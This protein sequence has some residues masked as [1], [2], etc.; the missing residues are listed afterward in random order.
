M[1]LET[2]GGLD[3][4]FLSLEAP[5]APLQVAAVLLLDPPEGRRSLFSPSTR[6]AQIRR[7]IGERISLVPALR[8]R[9]VPIPLGLHHPV[10]ADDPEFA[11]D[12]HLSRAVLPAPG[13]MAELSDLVAAVM[14]RPLDPDRPLWEVVVVEGMADGRTAMVMKLHHA[15]LDGVSGASLLANFLDLGPRSR[16]VPFP[17]TFDPSPLPGRRDLLAHAAR[18]IVH[19]PGVAVDALSQALDVLVDVSQQNRRLAEEGVTPPPAP[20]SAPRTRLNGT[21][22]S[23]R[24]FASVDLDLGAALAVREAYGATVTDVVLA[25]VAGGLR[26]YLGLEGTDTGDLVAMVPVSV[27]PEAEQDDLG[28]RVSAMLVSLATT[29]GGAVERLAKIAAGSSV[30]KSQHELTGGRLLAD[31]AQIAAPVVATRASRWATGLGLFDRLAPLSNV[32]ISSVRGPDMAIWCAGSRVSALM[33]VGP[34][35]GGVGLNVTAMSY[36]GRIQLGLLGCRRLV[37]DIDTLAAEVLGAF[38]ELAA[39]IDTVAEVAG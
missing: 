2:L 32:T 37:P 19:Q 13:T 33:P 39:T 7:V 22:S 9:A 16:P 11:L 6:V 3:A 21:I 27:R 36:L 34:V 4:A 12:D 26:R 38:E 18:S 20:F 25:S 28:N 14:S 5:G 1:S 10:W 8:Q 17:S 29:E 15:I 31:L 23:R 24:S 35:A 30:A